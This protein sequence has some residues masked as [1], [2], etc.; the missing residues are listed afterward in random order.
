MCKED[1]VE[2]HYLARLSEPTFILEPNYYIII[3][4]IFHRFSWRFFNL[5]L[6]YSISENIFRYPYSSTSLL[7]LVFHILRFGFPRL[8]STKFA[9]VLFPRWTVSF[10]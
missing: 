7:N 5:L 6:F 8:F 4:G 10:S 9:D 3:Q 2:K 1:S